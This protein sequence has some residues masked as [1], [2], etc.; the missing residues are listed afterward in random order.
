M[1][2][3]THCPSESEWDRFV[4]DPAIP[5]H[6]EMGR[7]L[8][9]CP[10][11]AMLVADLQREWSGMEAREEPAAATSGPIVMT[12]V[13]ELWT[14]SAQPALAAMGQTGPKEPESVTMA[15]P[16]R[17]VWLRAVRD[18]RTRDLW[19]YL[20]LEEDEAIARHAIVRP[21]GLEREFLTDDQGRINLGNAQWPQKEALKADVRLPKAEF[22]LRPLHSPAGESTE[23]TSPSGDRISL[24]WT[25]ERTNR[26]LEIGIAF[27]RDLIPGA[28]I[29]IAI[30]G[31][32]QAEPVTI[33]T[34]PPTG[35]ASFEGIE[36]PEG[37]EIYIYQ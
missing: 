5:E 37:L 18:P 12:I 29:R 36:D 17:V 32:R 35:T 22:S 31:S 20:Y 33:R 9:G 25:G 14:D 26:H 2:A 11:C 1:A 28:P 15:S 8:A 23:L 24:S 19:L 21:F 10:Y 16:D 27:L 34:I 7:H 13:S 3:F 30:R 4:I 6:D